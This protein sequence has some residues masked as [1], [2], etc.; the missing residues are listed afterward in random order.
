MNKNIPEYKEMLIV[1]GY[2]LLVL[3]YGGKQ[4]R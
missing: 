2:M 4:N 3:I 1:S